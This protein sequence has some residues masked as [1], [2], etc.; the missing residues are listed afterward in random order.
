MK[1]ILVT[2]SVVS[3]LGLSFGCNRQDSEQATGTG[4]APTQEQTERFPSEPS[5][6]SM[7]SGPAAGGTEMD[8]SEMGSDAQQ[9]E[10][11]DPSMGTESDSMMED[12][13]GSDVQNP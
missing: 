7:E 5:T 9:M 11:S 3:L 8:S 1:K 2:L 13:S 4:S 6:D 10:E 12:Q